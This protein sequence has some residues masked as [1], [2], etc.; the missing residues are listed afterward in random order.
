MLRLGTSA[1]ALAAIAALS[2]GCIITDDDG[3]SDLTIINDSSYTIEEIALAEVSEETW[4][5]NLL[6]GDV[7]FP[8]ESLTIVSIECGTYDVLVTDELGTDCELSN[9]RLC[10]DSTDWVVDDTTLAICDFGL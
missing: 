7:L 5:P 6:R 3:D 10:F 8:G 9:L 4:G 1:I 2:T